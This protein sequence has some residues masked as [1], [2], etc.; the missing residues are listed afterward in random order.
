MVRIA[1]RKNRW[2]S[3]P[4]RGEASGT[5][6]KVGAA[7]LQIFCTGLTMADAEGRKGKSV[8]G[9]KRPTHCY[10][11]KGAFGRTPLGD[12]AAGDRVRRN[13]SRYRFCTTTFAVT[14]VPL[15]ISVDSTSWPGSSVWRIRENVARS[16][17]S[18]SSRRT[19]MSPG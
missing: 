4:L 1:Q 19:R 14:C 7:K 8:A 2:T 15:R 10:V 9:Q 18:W 12:S 5:V 11:C 17:T 3:T 6:N 16:V 13:P